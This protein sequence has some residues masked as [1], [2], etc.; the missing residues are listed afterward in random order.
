MLLKE[1]RAGGFG[2]LT[3]GE[4]NHNSLPVTMESSHA[5]KLITL[6]ALY[7]SLLGCQGTQEQAPTPS[8]APSSSASSSSSS[9]TSSSPPTDDTLTI[10][11]GGTYELTTTPDKVVFS[12]TI[13]KNK[14]SDPRVLG[15]AYSLINSSGVEYR[16]VSFDYSLDS[17]GILA[18]E[19]AESD[20]GLT[21][22]AQAEDVALNSGEEML[23]THQYDAE[24]DNYG[25]AHATIPEGGFSLQPGYKLSV[26]SVSAIFPQSGGGAEVVDNSR[27]ADGTF[28]SM[29]YTVTFVRADLVSSSSVSSYRSPYRDRSYVSDPARK[30]APY[31]DFKNTSSSA[32]NVSAIG[33]FLSNLTDS[34]PST[35]SAEIY[36]NGNLAWSISLPPHDPGISSQPIPMILPISLVL[37]PG[38][39]V[40]VRGIVTPNRAIVFDF[41]SYLIADPGLTPFN[42]QLDILDI[43]LNNDGMKDIVDI[44]AKG[45][46][47][48][49]LRVG[50]DLQ[51]T[52]QE[53]ARDVKN[54][55]SLIV[56]P[57]YAGTGAPNLRATNSSGLCLN[58]QNNYATDQFFP[59]YC[60]GDP[61]S[62][63]YV[64]GD[65]NGDGWIDRMRISLTSNIYYVAL[66]GPSGLGPESGWVY[67]YGA[68]DRMFVSDS[69]GDGLS[70]IEAEWTDVGGFECVIWVSTGS[71]FTKTPCNQ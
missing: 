50:N 68:V 25:T 11:G 55:Q 70:D 14:T 4:N 1:R 13:Q 66:G 65:F 33:I 30:T 51:N 22:L 38:D 46:I 45:S 34:Q 48:V 52:E 49:S 53:W 36:V 37:N 31:T 29:A 54:V 6:V 5:V 44:D 57:D 60:G 35:H 40:S 56:S 15:G 18:G 61:A 58:L 23:M 2:A 19:A 63:A 24:P 7:L 28:M 20:M 64:W 43:D 71:S 12:G 69:N 67:G 16:A 9:S 32:V 8:S 10:T 42:E 39:V 62:P 21:I 26:G 59:S 17:S 41:S 47:W 27:L 3:G